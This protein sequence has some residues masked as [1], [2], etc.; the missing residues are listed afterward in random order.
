MRKR[1][2]FLL[3]ILILIAGTVML[4]TWQHSSDSSVTVFVIDSGFTPQ[5]DSG[6]RARVPAA[7]P[8]HG[9]LTGNI[10][11]R[12]A[13][14]D[15]RIRE[16]E[17]DLGGEDRR[18][19]FYKHL[20]YIHDYIQA[21]P[22]RDVI[23]NISL[24]FDDYRSQEQR[25]MDRISGSGAL[26]VAAAGN[27]G[28]ERNFYP[29]AYRGVFSVTGADS[30]GRFSYATYGEHVDIAASG[31]VSRLLPRDFSTFSLTRY[32]MQGTSFSAP[33]VVGDLARLSALTGEE[34]TA[35][36]LAKISRAEAGDISDDLYR[37]GKL[38][39]GLFQPRNVERQVIPGIFWRR[40]LIYAG[41]IIF[42]FTCPF[43]ISDM[44]KFWQ[45][46]K[47]YGASDERELVEAA[48]GGRTEVW[49]RVLDRIDNESIFAEKDFNR[50]L[51]LSGEAEGE[52][53]NYWRE[54]S[55]Q[56][57][58]NL[59]S[60][61]IR[62][63]KK[64]PEKLAKKVCRL[65]PEGAEEAVRMVDWQQL[66]KPEPKAGELRFLM[67]LMLRLEYF[68][69]AGKIAIASLH[70]ENDPWLIHYSLRVIQQTDMEK[71]K[72]QLARKINLLSKENHPLNSKEIEKIKSKIN[73]SVDENSHN[74]NSTTE[75]EN[76]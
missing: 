55:G 67:A 4:L 73:F 64:D 8:G 38:G 12:R 3:L 19:N 47:I 25:M 41:I 58:F 14:G 31:R 29:A 60:D 2:G 52:L 44:K 57:I 46:R 56:E 51:L 45:L 11:A 62:E 15:V 27:S 74:R 49:N 36:S 17:L 66:F 18:S 40:R 1:T 13:S 42:V 9:Q 23:I 24:A 6:V 22:Q 33:R 70:P 39:A 69:E 28:D 20:I 26:I 68:T 53:R 71:C 7:L 35:R 30:R 72:K 61:L 37:E 16:L 43:L 32:E 63:E 54:F 21:N 75:V 50:Q 59:V 10:I 76:H 34:Y 48:A 65:T 5:P